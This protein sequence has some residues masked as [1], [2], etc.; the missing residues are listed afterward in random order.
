MFNIEHPSISF[1]IGMCIKSN[2]M[3]KSNKSLS[4]FIELYGNKL[5]ENQLKDLKTLDSVFSSSTLES[6]EGN[7]EYSKFKFK[8]MTC[9]GIGMDTEI[10]IHNF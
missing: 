3:E 2:N 6:H 8:L 9:S 1:L 5:S 4:E 7:K 10:V